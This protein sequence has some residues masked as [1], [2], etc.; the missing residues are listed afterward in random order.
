MKMRSIQDKK[1]MSI[2]DMYPAVLTIVLVG[3]VLGIGLYVLATFHD[4]IATTQTEIELDINASSGTTTAV[5]ASLTGFKLNSIVVLNNTNGATLTNYTLTNAGVIT[6][7]TNIIEYSALTTMN[8]TDTYIYDV[9][10]SAE[11][12]TATTITGLATFADW[13]AI[14]VVVIAAAIVLGIVLTSFGRRRNTI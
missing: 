12:A 14:I 9:T 10:G 2:G 3:I 6:W 7:G 1:G 5:N 4:Q 13:I 8:V 11:E